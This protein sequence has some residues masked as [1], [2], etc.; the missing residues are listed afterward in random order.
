MGV[1]VAGTG[2]GKGDRVGDHV[3]DGVEL[4]VR[5]RVG[6]GSGLGVG[7]VDGRGLGTGVSVQASGASGASA[8]GEAGVGLQ[9]ARSDSVDRHTRSRRAAGR[10]MRTLTFPHHVKEIAKDVPRHVVVLAVSRGDD[11]LPVPA[12]PG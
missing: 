2:L 1:G 7:V 8:A 6:D 11:L 9:A 5:L 10:L 3:G 4:G 12:L